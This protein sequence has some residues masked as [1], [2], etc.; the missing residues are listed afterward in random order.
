MYDFI[1]SI[2][3][4]LCSIQE[5]LT[6]ASAYGFGDNNLYNPAGAIY[7]AY[8]LMVIIALFFI[9]LFLLCCLVCCGG[10]AFAVVRTAME[11]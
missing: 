6:S 3:T 5:A 9:A 10:T 4:I 11:K 7:G 1:A 2:V 8:G